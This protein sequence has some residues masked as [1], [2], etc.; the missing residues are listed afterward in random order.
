V[1]RLRLEALHAASAQEGAAEKAVKQAFLAGTAGD[2]QR[3]NV[4]FGYFSSGAFRFTVP[5]VHAISF[6]AQPQ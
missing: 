5:R 4:L 6:P 1:F 3:Y 2:E